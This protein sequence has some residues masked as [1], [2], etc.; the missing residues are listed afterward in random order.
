MEKRFIKHACLFTILERERQKDGGGEDGQ[1]GAKSQKGDV[2]ST[3]HCSPIHY[4]RL[5][6]SKARQ[7]K[8]VDSNKSRAGA[9]AGNGRKEIIEPI[10]PAAKLIIYS[11]ESLS[12][13][14]LLAGLVGRLKKF[15]FRISTYNPL[16][17][18]WGLE[19][20]TAI[21]SGIGWRAGW[22]A[23]VQRRR[24]IDGKNNVL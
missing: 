2:Q 7:Y 1:S 23:G 9:R 4:R 21:N 17:I 12:V 24:V 16:C 3:S 14:V 5:T 13:S 19:V 20:E 11:R 22:Q 8:K 10:V 18:H 15:C 6:L